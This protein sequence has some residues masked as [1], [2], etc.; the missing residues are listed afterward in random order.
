MVI[1]N[2]YGLFLAYKI[3]R[4][5]KNAKRVT[6]DFSKSYRF[7]INEALP[8]AEQIVD[9]FHILKNLTEDMQDYLKSNVR[10]KIK[11]SDLINVSMREKEVL[12]KRE[13]RKIETGLKRWKVDREVQE[14]S[15]AGKNN[16]EIV[17]KLQISR[18]MVIKYLTMTESPIASRPCKLDTYIPRIKEL[19]LK[20]YRY[21]EIFNQLK[22]EGYTGGF[23]YIIVK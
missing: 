18:P 17:T 8:G 23:H 2:R 10:D 12:N 4:K 11:I 22:M 16:T 6:R 13:R 5:F 7:A 9:R 14:L 3:L 15:R 19:L 1:L 21:M 20:G